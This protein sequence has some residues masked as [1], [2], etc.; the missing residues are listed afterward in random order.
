MSESPYR[1]YHTM[2]EVLEE[3][4][5]IVREIPNELSQLKLKA[6]LVADNLKHTVEHPTG[7]MLMAQERFEHFSKHDRP[8]MHDV[9]HNKQDQ[10]RLAACRIISQ[11]H[12]QSLIPRGWDE[13]IWNKMLDKTYI[14]RLIVSGSFVAAEIDRFKMEKVLKD[15]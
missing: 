5:S 10:L 13:Q 11:G 12:L 8:V 14:G 9:K 15:S 7:I 4:E 3:L 2:D 1:H 6:Q